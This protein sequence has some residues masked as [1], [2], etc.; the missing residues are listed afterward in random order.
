MISWQTNNTNKINKSFFTR[1]VDNW[2]FKNKKKLKTQMKHET[3]KPNQRQKNI[4]KKL[5][6]NKLVPFIWRL[7]DW[8]WNTKNKTGNNFNLSS[9]L[10]CLFVFVKDRR[11]SKKTEQQIDRII[12]IILKKMKKTRKNTIKPD[13]M[14]R[15]KNKNIRRMIRTLNWIE[16]RSWVTGEKCNFI[17]FLLLLIWLLWLLFW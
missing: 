13:H 16:T 5:G 6:D 17:S 8:K 14:E 1:K 2:S 9:T 7:N 12:I 10:F 11:I 15:H 4:F 3:N